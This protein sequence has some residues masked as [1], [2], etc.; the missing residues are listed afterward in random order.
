MKYWLLLGIVALVQVILIIQL[1][2]NRIQL[3]INAKLLK[4]ID[5]LERIINHV[6]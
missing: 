6:R 5:R 4:R 2:Q 1:E 3:E